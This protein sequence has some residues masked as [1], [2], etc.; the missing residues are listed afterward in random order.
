[1]MIKNQ[2]PETFHFK[3]GTFTAGS[4]AAMLGGSG[5]RLINSTIKSLTKGWI[6]REAQQV[7]AFTRTTPSRPCDFFRWIGYTFRWIADAWN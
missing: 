6:L 7:E 2:I 5:T 3:W 4:I 1:M